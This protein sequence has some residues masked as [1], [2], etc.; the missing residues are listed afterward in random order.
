MVVTHSLIHQ[1]LNENSP[2]KVETMIGGEKTDNGNY[3][4]PNTSNNSIKTHGL[5][6]RHDRMKEIRYIMV[7]AR[8]LIHQTIQ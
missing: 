6:H 5:K 7:V 4:Q 2:A 1:K 3:S 8:S